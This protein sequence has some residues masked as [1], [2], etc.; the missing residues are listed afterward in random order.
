MLPATQAGLMALMAEGIVGGEMAWPLVVA[1]MFLAGGLILI[2][3]PS[4]ML[5]AVWYVPA[6][7]VHSRHFRRGHD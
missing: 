5:I 2:N 6:F 1:G 3:A 7:P 4:P